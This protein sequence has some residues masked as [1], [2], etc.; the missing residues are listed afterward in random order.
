MSR[1]KEKEHMKK[2]TAITLSCLF[3]VASAVGGEP[4]AADQKW[5]EVVSKKVTE[6]Q[7]KAS[8]PSEERVT[9]A[10]EWASKK[11]YTVDVAKTDKSFQLTF[12]KQI[13]SK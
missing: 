5:L 1:P 4:S 11:G 7:T 10:K 13:A 3:V 2:F 12:A 9:L 6:G 8:T